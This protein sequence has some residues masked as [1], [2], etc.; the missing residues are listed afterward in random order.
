MIFE[1]WKSYVQ[2]NHALKLMEHMEAIRAGVVTPNLCTIT[3]KILKRTK[4]ILIDA[5]TIEKKT[6]DF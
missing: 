4:I 3:I 6:P 2:Q 5:L 1:V